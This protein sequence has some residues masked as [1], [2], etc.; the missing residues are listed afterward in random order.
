MTKFGVDKRE[1]SCIIM[2]LEISQYTRVLSE[3]LK[4]IIIHFQ[5]HLSSKVFEKFCHTRKMMIINSFQ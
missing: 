3:K 1:I 4:H 2:T 5:S